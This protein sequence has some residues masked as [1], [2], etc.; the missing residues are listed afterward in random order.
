MENHKTQA[1][2]M[3]N[4]LAIANGIMVFISV[5]ILVF[6]SLMIGLDVFLRYVF[7]SPLPATVDISQLLLPWIGFLPFAYTLATGRHVRVT[8]VI[9]KLPRK[10]RIF[11]DIL[12]YVTAF[13]FFICLCYYSWR[14][15]W[16]SL[17]INEIMLAAI[18]LPWWIGKFA[19]PLGMFFIA[20]QCVYLIWRN[21]KQLK[22][23]T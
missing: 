21:I 13:T 10:L 15:F 1:T 4:L 3:D 16:H 8:L 12:A 7:N 19:L 11:A 9:T 20:V 22:E 23:Q 2:K 18:N 14:E 6:I 17:N 5:V